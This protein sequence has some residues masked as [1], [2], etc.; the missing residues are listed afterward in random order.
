[1]RI[2]LQIA[3]AIISLVAAST[4]SAA[5]GPES[6]ASH[7]ESPK[8]FKF[9]KTQSVSLKY[10]LF[11]PKGYDA[12]ASKRWP[13]IFFLHG[14]GERGDN[15]WKVATH[16]PPK[17]V[18]QNPD[19]PFVVVSPQCPE[20]EVW[21]NDILLSLLDEVVSTM[22][23]DT[24]RIYLTG[25]SMGGYGTWYLGLSH[26]ERFAAIVPI[27]GG[28]EIL[29]VLLASDPK[30]QVLKSLGVWAFHGGK[31]PVVPLEESQRMVDILK[32]IGAQDVKLTV[33]PEAGHDAWT[34]AYKNPEL[35]Q[36]LLSHERRP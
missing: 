1:M 23:V 31:D 30:K 14:A 34:E 6:S 28:G 32:K 3:A 9:Q 5:S 36:W 4:L 35:Y 17:N 25:L 18:A 20:G 11:L 22:K 13:L 27:C 12:A 24:N 19:F 26:P 16:G 21:S 33:F 8:E 2:L 15:T 7:V 10:L 29:S